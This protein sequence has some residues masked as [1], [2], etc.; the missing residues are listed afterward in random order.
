[1]LSTQPAADATGFS[2]AFVKA[3]PLSQDGKYPCSAW[4][5]S[6]W[7]CRG[8]HEHGQGQPELT[9]TEVPRATVGAPYSYRLETTSKG[10]CQEWSVAPDSL[11]DGLLLDAM[12]NLSGTPTTPGD[13]S[14]TVFISNGFGGTIEQEA[15]LVV[16]GPPVATASP[17][18]GL[19]TTT[20]DLNGAVDPRN[21]PAEA[22]FEYWP[23]T[24]SSQSAIRTPTEAVAKGLAPVN[25]TATI[26]GLPPETEY[27]F[28]LAAANELGPDPVYSETIS[29]TSAAPPPPPI[30]PA[31]AAPATNP[32]DTVPPPTAGENFDVETVEGTVTTKCPTD[33]AFSGLVREEQI[34]VGCLIDT[35]NGTVRLTASKGGGETQSAFFWGGL[36]RVTQDAGQNQTVALKLA[37]Q[38]RCE[39]RAGREGRVQM[40]RSGGGRKLWGSG[41]GNYKTVGSHGAATVRGTIWLVQDRCDRSTLVKVRRGTVWVEDFVK[42]IQ[43]VLQAGEQYLIE[44]PT[45]RLGK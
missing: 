19:T 3:G 13:Y 12:G 9:E 35:T 4:T 34:P 36:F 7:H 30:A 16:V 1:M 31:S 20:A 18:T 26:G 43:V 24:G 40:R 6:W 29:L 27:L 22:W 32:A 25:L 33:Q 2:S 42:G 28:R 14:F 15:T 38:L 41:E 8:H 17:A 44:P 45:P 5:A 11:P 37:G 21:L 23:A 39:R 10:R